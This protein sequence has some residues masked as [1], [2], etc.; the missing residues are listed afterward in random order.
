MGFSSV[1][2][3]ATLICGGCLKS[4][5]PDALVSDAMACFST[6]KRPLTEDQIEFM[7]YIAEK[8]ATIAFEESF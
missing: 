6:D 5:A 7:E 2:V 4:T 3:A 8:Q 1:E